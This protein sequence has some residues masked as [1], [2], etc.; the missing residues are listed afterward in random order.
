MIIPSYFGDLASSQNLQ[1]IIDQS[2]DVLGS[3][4]DMA[5]LL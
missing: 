1:L 3:A 4:V 5:Q 2:Q